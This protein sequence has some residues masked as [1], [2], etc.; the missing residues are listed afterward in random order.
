MRK[1]RRVVCGDWSDRRSGLG[2]S[3]RILR[4]AVWRWMIED[5]EVF[6]GQREKCRDLGKVWGNAGGH[7]DNNDPRM[8]LGRGEGKQQ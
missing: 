5:G 7:Q 1:N 8:G 2:L 3:R 6:W 4:R